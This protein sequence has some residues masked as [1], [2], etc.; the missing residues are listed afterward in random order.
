[1]SPAGQTDYDERVPTSTP[2]HPTLD[3]SEQAES[4]FVSCAKGLEYLLVDELLA[5]G[6]SRATAALAGVHVEAPLEIAL[7]AVLWSR[8]ASRVLWPLA[9]FECPDH[10][11]LY[12]EVAKL[13]WQEHLRPD[14]TLAI[15][16]HVSGSEL[17]HERFAAQRVKDAIV[18]VLRAATGERPSVDVDAPDLR[19]GLSVRKGRATLSV[20]LGGGSLHKRG[21]RKA[22]GAAPLKENVAAAVLLRGGWPA[23]YASGGVLLDPMCGS[24]TLLIEGAAMAADVAPGLLRFGS[25]Q[26]SRWLGF[27]AAVWSAL[28]DEATRRERDGRATLRAAFFGS[29]LDSKALAVARQNLASAGFDAVT[30]LQLKHV[31][32]LEAVPGSRGVGLVATNPPYAARM[33]ADEA[34]YRELGDALK[35]ALPTFR[36]SLLCGSVELAQA[37]GLRAKKRYQLFNGTLECALLLCDPIL[38][39]TRATR[40]HDT[41]SEGATMV[42]NRLR[43]NLKKLEPWAAREGISCFRAYDGDLP[44]YAA[45]IDVYAT[46][47]GTRYLHVQE[48]AAP[49]DIPERDVKRR[50][51]ELLA[52]ARDAFEL[53][54]ERIVLD[55]PSLRG[56]QT[57]APRILVRE[58]DAKLHV[59]LGRGADPGLR[60]DQRI[61]RRDIAAAARGK[62]FLHLA[63]GAGAASVLAALAG[64]ETLTAVD[65]RGDNLDWLAENLGENAVP[66]ARR[67]LIEHEL[68]S[69]LQG[70]HG[71]WDVILF[72]A[73]VA[74]HFPRPG[75]LDFQRTHVRLLEAAVHVLA[76]NGVLAFSDRM[77][78]FRFDSSAVSAFAQIE[79]VTARTIPRD[80][81]R[82]PRIHRTWML[83]RR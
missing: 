6:A 18:D 33:A 34:L 8:L 75:E 12:T 58:G 80:F 51:G 77:H 38:D 29:D 63:P 65:P 15:D 20:D 4:F 57:D 48:P 39:S 36:A 37:T 2:E 59:D 69:W 54:R 22:Q 44:E 10:D 21:W 43:K 24:G 70:A 28:R 66:P 7:R 23:L 52:A 62:R 25:T 11:A 64:A 1:M 76:P 31:R 16:A 72:E 41:L 68:I 61:G 42:R 26:P 83:R 50:R 30:S 47:G 27:P 19:L 3:A 60:L 56:T 5:L 45:A 9:E 67:T 53:P 17:T 79:D 78:R 73:P 40:P 82:T 14:Q 49:R 71:E 32:A 13:A 55:E 74:L 46:T 35:R 81:E